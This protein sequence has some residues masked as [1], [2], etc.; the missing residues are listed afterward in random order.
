MARLTCCEFEDDN[1]TICCCVAAQRICKHEIFQIWTNFVEFGRCGQLTTI[2]WHSQGMARLPPSIFRV[3]FLHER[4]LDSSWL[5][6]HLWPLTPSVLYPAVKRWFK[7]FSSTNLLFLYF[8]C[9]SMCE[10]VPAFWDIV[11]T[12]AFKLFRGI[13]PNL[14]LWC[15]RTQRW[16]D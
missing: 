2:H 1:M 5:K 8:Q 4:C 14:Q 12:I 16:T 11:N 7:T 3:L 9:I 13:S 10:W 15:S 6:F